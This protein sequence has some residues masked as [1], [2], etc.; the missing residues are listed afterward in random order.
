MVNDAR[1]F[2]GFNALLHGYTPEDAFQGDAAEILGLGDKEVETLFTR[3]KGIEYKAPA[4]DPMVLALLNFLRSSEYAFLSLK[5]QYILRLWDFADDDFNGRM[6]K[7]MSAGVLSNLLRDYAET[8]EEGNPYVTDG[9]LCCTRTEFQGANKAMQEAYKLITKGPSG[10]KKN[11]N[12]LIR[13]HTTLDPY[14]PFGTVNL[15][16]ILD[17]LVDAG[18]HP[19]VCQQTFLKTPDLMDTYKSTGCIMAYSE[20]DRNS[21]DWLMDVKGSDDLA[22]SVRI[23]FSTLRNHLLNSIEDLKGAYAVAARNKTTYS[24]CYPGD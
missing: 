1:R 24:I 18:I 4:T 16:E 15:L 10:L 13:Q 3:L 2:L 23:P 12:L 19:T 8:N 6:A 17:G 20:T 21:I 14:T 7:G 5:G 9:V 22:T 11:L